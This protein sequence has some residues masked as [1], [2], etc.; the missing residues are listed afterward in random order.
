MGLGACFPGRF[1]AAHHAWRPQ[2][3]PRRAS[4]AQP[5]PQGWAQLQ[6][7]ASGS[8]QSAQ[9]SVAGPRGIGVSLIPSQGC[10]GRSL[11]RSPWYADPAWAG[12]RMGPGR[13]QLGV[14]RTLF[15]ARLSLDFSPS[16]CLWEA[17]SPQSG[18][19]AQR[20]WVRAGGFRDRCL[21]AGNR[22]RSRPASCPPEPLDRA[23]A[24]PCPRA[25][26]PESVTSD[27]VRS[28]PWSCL[29]WGLFPHS[30]PSAAPRSL[31]HPT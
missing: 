16:C 20:V 24:T 1:C 11:L 7:S 10:L 5:A 31:Q 15:G 29:P 26:C 27:L 12:E 19:S 13:E 22:A 4:S 25:E 23:F 17:G 6:D 28:L 3:S 14:L 9:V 8:W 21:P 18:H 30:S 2:R